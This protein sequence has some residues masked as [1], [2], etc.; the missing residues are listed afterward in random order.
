MASEELD[1]DRGPVEAHPAVLA[2][3]HQA[4]AEAP[5]HAGVP[6]LAVGAGGMLLL[7]L[8]WDAFQGEFYRLVLPHDR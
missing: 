8:P 7:E 5:D 2:A 6:V 3:E 4:K 1:A